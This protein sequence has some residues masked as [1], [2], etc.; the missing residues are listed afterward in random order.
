METDLAARIRKECTGL[1]IEATADNNPRI[2]GTE[3]ADSSTLIHLC[4]PRAQYSRYSWKGL[5]VPAQ[6]R[7]LLAGSNEDF[8]N[9]FCTSK[10]FAFHYPIDQKKVE[11][12]ITEMEKIDLEFWKRKKLEE[13]GPLG[14]YPEEFD[15]PIDHSPYLRWFQQKYG[16]ASC[17][18]MNIWNYGMLLGH[19]SL[20]QEVMD[21]IKKGPDNLFSL[22]ERLMPRQLSELKEDKKRAKLIQFFDFLKEPRYVDH[23]Y[24]YE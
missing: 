15:G 6:F 5:W 19:R 7:V 4:E 1:F 12:K 9:M 8:H 18:W 22:M 3:V 16:D 10:L 13:K 17:I 23:H 24:H 20:M 21:H 2:G 14:I 11:K